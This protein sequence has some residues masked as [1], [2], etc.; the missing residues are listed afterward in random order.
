MGSP[1]I[2]VLVDT[3]NHE[4]FIED[5]VTSVLAQ[6]FPA[7][8]MEI[9][10][11]DDG[12]TDRTPEILRRF[13]PRVRLIRKTNGGQASA[14]NTG[15]AEARGQIIAFLDGDDWWAR[16]KLRQVADTFVRR[17][18]AG[19]MGH[20]IIEVLRDGRRRLETLREECHFQ[21]CLPGGADILRNRKHLLGTSRL[22]IRTAIAR[23]IT[24]LPENL[25]FEADEFLFTI[26][27]VLS[28]T[29]IITAALAYYRHHDSNLYQTA[30]ANHESGL[31]KLRVLQ[32]L[33]LALELRL[34]SEHVSREARNLILDAIHAEESQL[35]LS[36]LGGPRW[37][38]VLTE[39]RLLRIH[40]SEAG[41]MQRLFSITRI[42]PAVVIPA[43]RYYRWKGNVAQSSLYL[44]LRRRF[45]PI[46]LASHLRREEREVAI[47]NARNRAY[48]GQQSKHQ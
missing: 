45:L 2:S 31:R 38:A 1:L 36:L 9:L 4:R 47:V 44:R 41:L 26:A 40:H 18:Q 17:P 6:D 13:F 33:Y 22:A 15:I 19:I 48:T 7:N 11:I 37:E 39:L 3:Y 42:L 30:S 5:A 24:P 21:A 20:G 32:S 29:V 14:F 43:R 16:G 23:Q 46:P 8:E 34:N 25:I 27:A 28:E 12:S 35:R 10:A